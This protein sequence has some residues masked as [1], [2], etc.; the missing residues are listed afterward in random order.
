MSSEDE[1]GMLSPEQYME[2]SSERLLSRFVEYAKQLGLGRAMRAIGG[3]PPVDGRI[4]LQS[5]DKG[6]LVSDELLAV[7]A[8]LRMRPMGPA[9]LA[10]YD[11]PD[12]D[13]RMCSATY[14]GDVDPKLAEATRTGVRSGRSARDVT[15][16]RQRVRQPPPPRPTLPEMSDEALLARFQDAGERLT[17]CEFI[18]W[19]HD[20]RDMD[21]R[22]AIIGELI[23]IRADAKR[24]ALLARLVPFLDSP[25]PSIR[26]HAAIA[27][28]DFAPDKA[29]AA[30]EGLETDDDP[31]VRAAVGW[32][33]D[34][35]RAEHTA[36]T[37]GAA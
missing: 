33:L 20:K 17:A 36:P 30:L 16:A 37:G 28:L 2:M 31:Q 13:V 10:L 6:K 34:R 5:P 21:T 14:F 18:D 8:A 24:R 7:A 15:A 29:V 23:A 1:V 35:W 3:G 26:H 12:P 32:T 22:N 25:D 19:V 11:D 9:I 4:A 27:C